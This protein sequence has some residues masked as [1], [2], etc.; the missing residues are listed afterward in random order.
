MVKKEQH[1]KNRTQLR[2]FICYYLGLFSEWCDTGFPENSKHSLTQ[3]S[4]LLQSLAQ[5]PQTVWICHYKHVQSQRITEIKV[6][7]NADITKFILGK[8][9]NVHAGLSQPSPTPAQGRGEKQGR[10]PATVRELR[11]EARAAHCAGASR[12]PLGQIGRQGAGAGLRQRERG[13]G[14]QRVGRHLDP[15]H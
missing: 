3:S 12:R 10:G 5:I 11:G 8:S 9:P 13:G 1:G 6:K 7:P 4:L 14:L 15:S 2:E